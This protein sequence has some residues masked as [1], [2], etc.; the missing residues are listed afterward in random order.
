MKIINHKQL[1]IILK[2]KYNYPIICKL[3]IQQLRQQ[4]FKNKQNK[5]KKAYESYK[6]YKIFDNG[7]VVKLSR[8]TI[9][10][11]IFYTWMHLSY[12]SSLDYKFTDDLKLTKKYYIHNEYGFFDYFCLSE[13]MYRMINNMYLCDQDVYDFSFKEIYKKNLF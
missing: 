1:L 8:Y 2:P 12:V 5:F 9:N 3:I 13:A 7:K 11:D 4:R 6:V 10:I